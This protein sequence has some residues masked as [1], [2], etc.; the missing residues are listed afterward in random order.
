M[1][2][3]LVQIEG[4][5]P[6]PQMIA[7][8]IGKELRLELRNKHAFGGI[9]I[10]VLSTIFVCY[11]SFTSLIDLTTWNALF[12][13]IL[14]F[15]SLNAVSKTFASESNARRL[16]LYT[17]ASPQAIIVSKILYNII[18][19]VVLMTV[20]LF[21]YGLTIGTEAWVSSDIHPIGE[22][23]LGVNLSSAELLQS[24]NVP[25]FVLSLVLGAI[26][27]A[28]VFTLISAIAAQTN[29]NLGITAILGFPVILPMLLL[30]IDFSQ[31]ALLGK[32]MSDVLYFIA[33]L[34]GLNAICMALAYLLFPYLW[35]S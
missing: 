32:G 19:V 25:M 29:N 12:W 15:A 14:L 26:G 33:V 7:T 31:N 23:A 8:L 11:L 28:S 5:L 10:Y 9:L 22:G 16:Y 18:V 1:V 2:L 35:R 27:F 3:Q 34:L 21:F 17:L 24:S 4:T 6:L 30:L 13:I 20:S